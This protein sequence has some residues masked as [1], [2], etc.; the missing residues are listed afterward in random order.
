MDLPEDIVTKVRQDFG[1]DDGLLVLQEL[2]SLQS[3]F[4][5]RVLRC[6]VAL[7]KGSIKKFDQEIGAARWDCRDVIVAAEG[8]ACNALLMNH[9][10][11]LHL[12]QALCRH[13]LIGQKIPLPWREERDK[14]WK[15][16]ASDIRELELRRIE[17]EDPVEGD[18]SGSET[19]RVAIRMLCAR[20]RWVCSSPAFEIGVAVWYSIDHKTET[21]TLR[22][23][24]YNPNEIKQRGKWG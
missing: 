14:P 16:E 8:W 7:A 5:N 12:D 2:K 6:I 19:Y 11:P 20:G 15:I 4:G 3:E 17:H 22:R 10:F 23:M 18:I 24:K 9:P 13:W 21:F 1:E